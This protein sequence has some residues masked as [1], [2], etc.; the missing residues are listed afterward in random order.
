MKL[1][2]YNFVNEKSQGSKGQFI[3]QRERS[4]GIRKEVI[5]QLQKHGETEMY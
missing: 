5:G 2:L 1:L 3:P 4:S